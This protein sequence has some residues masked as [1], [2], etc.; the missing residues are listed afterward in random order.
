M[1]GVVQFGIELLQR[2]EGFGK[3]IQGLEKLFTVLSKLLEPFLT[4]INA[5]VNGLEGIIVGFA[6]GISDVWN[7]I[8]GVLQDVL[9]WIPGVGEDLKNS[10]E[11]IKMNLDETEI[12]PK[13]ENTATTSTT[14]ALSNVASS[15]N[16]AANALQKM[17]YQTTDVP[18]G[19]KVALSR[20]NAT[21]TGLA[22]LSSCLLYTSDAA[23]D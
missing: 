15:A 13:E 1:A 16:I 14:S 17:S 22:A 4:I 3:L 10:L 11:S 20:F 23:D 6:K 12:T 21:D 9:S 8:V 5:V 7:A 18:E 2:T 19:F